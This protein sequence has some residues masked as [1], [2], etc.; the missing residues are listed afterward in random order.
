M[1][2]EEEGAFSA[3]SQSLI[4]LQQSLDSCSKAIEAGDF[5]KSE[6]SISEISE[7]LGSISDGAISHPDDDTALDNAITILSHIQSY[8]F[9]PSIDQVRLFYCST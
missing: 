9:N 5:R 3:S 8:L 4:R 7:L 2:G 1:S 6:D